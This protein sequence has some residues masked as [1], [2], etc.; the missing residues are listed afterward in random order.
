MESLVNAYYLLDHSHVKD[1]DI[2]DTWGQK[3][4][5]LPL[6][7]LRRMAKVFSCSN[8]DVMKD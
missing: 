6:V 1:P 7:R 8:V 5:N 3:K 4:K 2:S